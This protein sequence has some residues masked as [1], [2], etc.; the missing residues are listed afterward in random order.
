[1]IV[2]TN[3]DKNNNHKQYHRHQKETKNRQKITKP[4]PDSL[5]PGNLPGMGCRSGNITVKCNTPK[6]EVLRAA[7]LLRL[8]SDTTRSPSSPSH[9]RRSL[10][11]HMGPGGAW[12]G[13]K[14]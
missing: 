4:K 7:E 13:R 9:R 12:R 10:R 3:I 1:M 14:G 5:S 8:V 2:I 11:Y 6:L